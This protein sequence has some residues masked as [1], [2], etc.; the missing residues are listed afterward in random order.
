MCAHFVCHARVLCKVFSRRLFSSV[1][2]DSAG[3]A[4]SPALTRA[5]TRGRQAQDVTEAVDSEVV[6]PRCEI[7][8]R[9]QEDP[10]ECAAFRYSQPSLFPRALHALAGTSLAP[11]DKQKR[12]SHVLRG[13]L[14]SPC[15]MIRDIA[16]QLAADLQ[17]AQG[18]DVE[19]LLYAA[20]GDA[21]E[22]QLRLDEVADTI[23]S[24]WPIPL[25]ALMSYFSCA[26]GR[27]T[28]EKVKP[29]DMLK[30][31][32]ERPFGW[33]HSAYA[34]FQVLQWRRGPLHRNSDYVRVSKIEREHFPWVIEQIRMRAP[35]F[36]RQY[37]VAELKAGKSKWSLV[38]QADGFLTVVIEK[39]FA[40][41]AMQHLPSLLER[42]QALDAAGSAIHRWRFAQEFRVVPPPL[43]AVA[44]AF[45]IDW[46]QRQHNLTVDT[47]LMDWKRNNLWTRRRTNKLKETIFPTVRELGDMA[48]A[49]PLRHRPFASLLSDMHSHEEDLLRLWYSKV[50]PEEPVL[51]LLWSR[52]LVRE[53]GAYV[54]EA[55]QAAAHAC[56]AELG[57]ASDAQEP[58]LRVLCVGSGSSRLRHYLHHILAKA[59]E[60]A[61]DLRMAAV[62]PAVRSSSL[63]QVVPQELL[64]RWPSTSNSEPPVHMHPADA[65]YTLDEALAAYR[66][67]LVVC[68][69]MPPRVDWSASFRR[70]PSV[71]EYILVGPAD[72]DLSGDL[73]STWGGPEP[74]KSRGRSPETPRF[75]TEGFVRHD[76]PSLSELV[77][78]TNDAPGRVGTNSVVA[79]RRLK[80]PRLTF[81]AD[82]PALIAGRTNELRTS[83]SGKGE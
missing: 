51:H 50:P 27:N 48:L 82:S 9:A 70:A 15:P 61:G 20:A 33:P 71:L 31:P 77:L 69:C 25:D 41:A 29:M 12:A 8:S 72:S 44:V 66:P 30:V 60:I 76:L 14:M 81:K 55:L 23:V 78:G 58:P 18:K 83:V 56:R 49:S 79:F 39:L 2:Q 38:L 57:Q 3:S 35:E 37:C 21:M 26:V 42:Q 73:S 11:L 6:L 1:L 75:A 54:L 4:V 22:A 64:A 5:P 47:P 63:G 43:A 46:R 52:E 74:F 40:L 53:L 10:A 34:F 59:P 80:K 17:Q 7:R 45:G 19:A 28:L 32:D 68:A 24:T 36:Y 16:S 65:D 67:H 62:V 13:A